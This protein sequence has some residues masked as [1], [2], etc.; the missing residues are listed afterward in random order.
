M[1]HKRSRLGAAFALSIIATLSLSGCS[2]IGGEKEKAVTPTIGNRVPVLGVQSD[3]QPHSS[4]AGVSI[5]LPPA[6]SN[7]EWPQPGGNAAKSM[8]HLSI[9]AA[10][11]QV[12]SQSIA[13]SS[14]KSRLAAAPIV[15]GGKLL[16]ADTK[17]IVHAFDAATGAALWS[18]KVTSSSDGKNAIFGGGVAAENGRVYAT[19]GTGDVEALDLETGAS[20]WKVRP[21]GPLRGAPTVANGNLYVM[22][23]DNQLYA[24]AQ[25]DGKVN[26]NEAA[27]LGRASI[28]GVAAP[29]AAQATVVAGFSTGELSAYRF[30]NGQNLWADALSRTNISTSVSTLTDIDASPVIDRGRV[31][32]VGKGG[33]MAAYELVTGQRI[34][35][36]N[37]GG[38]A[39]PAVSGDWLFVMSDN[40]KLIAVARGTG[41]IRW[42]SDLPAWRNAKKKKDA[43]RW[44][45]PLL[46]GGRVLVAG[47][48][49][50]LLEVSLTDGSAR[51]LANLGKS[52]SLPL[53]AAGEMMYILA[54]DGTL[55]AFR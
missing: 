13:G 8:G 38:I 5:I 32:A 29:A 18:H 10:P 3:V 46:A 11:A 35:E 47:T 23:L 43:I 19:N 1:T 4:L 26:W 36:L 42:V 16:A 20:L 2:A 55:M 21:A 34:W 28:Y 37:I 41:R 27:S 6:N 33:R 52:V 50:Q 53:I 39:T 40:A 30:E 31:Y 7:A 44:A 15:A 25:A 17:G 12:W 45:A 24:L 48:G 54:D 14:S 22:T 49:G 9:G 51:E